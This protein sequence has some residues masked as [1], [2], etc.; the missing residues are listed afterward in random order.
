[1]EGECD[2]EGDPEGD[3]AEELAEEL[4]EEP[5]DLGSSV[6]SVFILDLEQSE[7]DPLEEASDALVDS[8]SE[9]LSFFKSA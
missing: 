7:E 8:L 6:G 3:L 5:T 9:P 4:E 1:L 2:P